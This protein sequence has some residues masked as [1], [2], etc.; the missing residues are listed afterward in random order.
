M[1]KTTLAVKGFIDTYNKE[2]LGY[3]DL[4]LAIETICSSHVFK[5]LLHALVGTKAF[6]EAIGHEF[7]A[8]GA[9]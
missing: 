4:S 8:D 7:A 2:P 3:E 5:D 9:I 1:P 6:S